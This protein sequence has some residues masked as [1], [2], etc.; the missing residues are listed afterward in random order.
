MTNRSAGSASY[1]RK[2]VTAV[3]SGC[4]SQMNYGRWITGIDTSE[5]A[6]CLAKYEPL[7][8]VVE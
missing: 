7:T 5:F 3:P 4:D 8:N 2:A 6:I 1:N